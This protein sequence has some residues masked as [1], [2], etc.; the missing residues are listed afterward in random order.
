ML[1][2]TRIKR[3][4]ALGIL[5]CFF[6]PLCQCTVMPKASV[7]E[8]SS[9]ALQ[10]PQIIVYAGV[11]LAADDFERQDFAGFA[12]FVSAFSWPVAAMALHSRMRGR[13][14]IIGLSAV[15][16]VLGGLSVWGLLQLLRFFPQLRYG[17]ALVLAFVPGYIACS[18]AAIWQIVKQKDAATKPA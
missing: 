4:L 7:P 6:L 11:G 12:F 16:V 15:E 14:A 2:I 9:K 18:G 3:W 1:L 17:G 8:P 13:T 10:A 5:A